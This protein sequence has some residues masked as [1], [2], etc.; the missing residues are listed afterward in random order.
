MKD[1]DEDLRRGELSLGMKAVIVIALGLGDHLRDPRQAEPFRRIRVRERRDSRDDRYPPGPGKG[2]PPESPG[3]DDADGEAPALPELVDLGS[4]TCVPCKAMAPILE[5][6]K[7]EFG[8][9][10]EVTFIDVK[11]NPDAQ[12][13][14]DIRMIPTQIFLDA[15]GNEVFRHEGFFSRKDILETWK[16]LGVE[17][18]A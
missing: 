3:A 7:E 15:E 13:L 10:F 18:D 5:A 16:K 17:V 2:T 9:R 11:K 4:T 8:T 12:T 6:L 14:Y 1:R